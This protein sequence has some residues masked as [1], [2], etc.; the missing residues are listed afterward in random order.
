MIFP[1]ASPIGICRHKIMN[2][3]QNRDRGL[4]ILEIV[5]IPRRIENYFQRQVSTIVFVLVSDHRDE[6]EEENEEDKDYDDGDENNE[7]GLKLLLLHNDHD[8]HHH[9]HDHHHLHHHDHHPHE[10]E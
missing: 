7:D 9:D 2:S 5:E 8:H 3:P 10:S 6:N 1:R 4:M